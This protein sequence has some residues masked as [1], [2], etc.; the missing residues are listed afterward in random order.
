MSYRVPHSEYVFH[1]FIWVIP[2]V[3]E[4]LMMF[5]KPLSHLSINCV[6]DIFISGS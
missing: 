5:G 1:N 2:F 6:I 4:L 3:E